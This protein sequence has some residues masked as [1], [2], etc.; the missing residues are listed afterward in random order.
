MTKSDNEKGNKYHDDEGKFTSPDGVGTVSHADEEEDSLGTVTLS[1]APSF[2]L[3][4]SA[5]LFAFLAG[6]K[7]KKDQEAQTFLDQGSQFVPPE[8]AE[9]YASLS[10]Q[11]KRDL[12][13]KSPNEYSKSFLRMATEKE[14]EALTYAEALQNIDTQTYQEIELAK[15]ELEAAKLKGHEKLDAFIA[16]H[17]VDVTGIWPVW[18]KQPTLADYES[19]STPKS[20]GGVSSIDGKRAYFNDIIEHADID[21]ALKD[22]YA[23]RLAKLDEF[24]ALGKQYVALKGQIDSE[25]LDEVAALEQKLAGLNAKKAGLESASIK[26]IANDYISRFQDPSAMYSA[27]RKNNAIWFTDEWAS[28]HGFE[29]AKE[30]ATKH[31]GDR[32]EKM[33]G[34]MTSAERSQ[35]ID[36]T[37]GGYSK[38]NK[39]LRGLSHSGWSGFGFAQAV[40]NITNA[41]DKCVWDQDMWVQR[42]IDDSRMF[43]IPGS[44]AL[45]TLGELSDGQLQ[46]LVGMSFVDNGFMSCGSGKGTGFSGNPVIFNLYCPKGTKGAYMNTHGHYS[47][48][49][50]NEMI[51]QRGYEYRITKIER[52][53]GKTYLDVDVILGSDKN[54]ITDMTEL[55]KIGNKYL[56]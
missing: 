25:N 4:N 7:E 16:E 33:W 55:A 31:F 36:Y 13:S 3:A 52:V 23:K 41:I 5:S 28:Q 44:D 56:Y 30:A 32:F 12:L 17:P 35:L 54:K 9:Y 15:K 18:K 26:K 47:Y 10:V 42:G 45:H 51:L 6:K 38:Y 49:N 20:P 22:L 24:E 19:L 53:G 43:R 48:T 8:S 50:E 39:P 11:E 34:T 1:K 46:S 2:K 27:A 37:G 14:I 40:T 21:E 29:D